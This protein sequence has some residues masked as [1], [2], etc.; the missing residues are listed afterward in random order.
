[1]RLGHPRRLAIACGL[2]VL[3]VTLFHARRAEAQVHWDIGVQGGVNKRF[4]SG[5]PSE[6][7]FGPM[8]QLQA[9]VALLPLVRVGGYAGWEHSPLDGDKAPRNM[10][11]GGLRVKV[12]SPWPR[13]DVRLWLF[14]G[15]GFQG[16]YA[17]S[18]RTTVLTEVT[19]GSP[20]S[21]LAPAP[22][23]VHGSGGRYF[24][25]P[26]GIGV[27]YKLRKP[28]ELF[29]ELGSKV[30]FAS[31]GSTYDDGPTVSIAGRPDANGTVAGQDR[32]SI[33]LSLGL[34]IDL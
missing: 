4:L 2:V 25:V 21:G 15:F 24:E 3:A 33:G 27:S 28:F 26:F 20:T 17:Q 6:A 18:Y 13:G 19:P 1:M 7:G 34:L 22:A 32:F 11:G 31:S 14:V 30:G 8:A 5:G 29:G 10:F 9:H 16:V 12:M 23:L